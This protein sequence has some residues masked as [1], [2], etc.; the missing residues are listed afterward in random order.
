MVAYDKKIYV[1]SSIEERGELKEITTNFLEMKGEKKENQEIS[2]KNSVYFLIK[3]EAHANKIK[4]GEKKK[5]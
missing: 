5:S 3:Y 2:K 1:F 4:K